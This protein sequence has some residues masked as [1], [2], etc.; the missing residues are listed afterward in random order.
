MSSSIEVKLWG[1]TLGYLGYEEGS[2]IAVF[3]YDDAFMKSNIL[4]SPLNMKYPPSRHSFLNTSFNTFKGVPGIFADSLPDKFG[5]QLIDQ[6]MAEKNIA[7]ANITTLDR[8]LYVGNRAMGAIEYH[9]YRL[10]N[11]SNKNVA[12]DMPL[13]SELAELV[14]NNKGDLQKELKNTNTREDALNLIRV[15]S[16]AGGARSKALVTRK[17]DGLLYDGTV[18]YNE[19]CSYW[20]LKFD[21][22]SN[23]DRDHGDPKGMTRVEYIYSLIARQCD[24]N[25][26]KTDYIEHGAD[27]Y[28]LIERFDR[29]VKDKKTTKLHYISWAGAAHFDRDASG[30]YSYEQLIMTMRSM[31]LGQDDVNEVFKRAVFNIVGRNQDDH[32]K[33]FGFLMNKKGVWKLSPAFD[34][35][36]AYDPTGK[37]TKVH[38]IKLNRKQDNFTEK[39]IVAFGKYCNITEKISLEIL[40]NTISEFLKFEDWATQYAVSKSL[41][42]TVL[43]NLRL[44][45]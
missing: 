30:S 25:M 24:I 40:E 18:L 1:T 33:N 41:K 23:K 32:T 34:M 36:Y 28:F 2:N 38:Q 35:T 14:V 5:S 31:G 39:D 22:E 43:S 10:N 21:S 11:E 26:P 7:P 6:F 19:N 13:L 45:F 8:L 27:F 20:L 42:D 17:A 3:E 4:I 9:P 37:W 29:V 15:G 12:L 16:S 44:K